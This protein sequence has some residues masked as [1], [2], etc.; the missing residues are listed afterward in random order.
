MK[1]KC[2]VVDDEALA[3]YGDQPPIVVKRI[4]AVEGDTFSYD[5]TDFL[6]NGES[7]FSLE[8]FP[9]LR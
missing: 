9:P 6:V 4:V 8:E 2:I 5:G 1:L 7:V 3:R